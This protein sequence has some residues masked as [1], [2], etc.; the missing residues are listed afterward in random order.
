MTLTG[1]ALGLAA[2]YSPRLDRLLMRLTSSH[3]LKSGD[4]NTYATKARH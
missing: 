1:S 3:G 2:G 4:S